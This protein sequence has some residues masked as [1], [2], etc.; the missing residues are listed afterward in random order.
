MIKED[1]VI[2]TFKDS[3]EVNCKFWFYNHD[4]EDKVYVEVGFPDNF[5]DP[6]HSSIPLKKFM[7][8]VNGKKVE[9][10]KVKQ[11]TEYVGEMEFTKNWFVWYADFPAQSVTFIENKYIGNWGGSYYSRFFS[12]EI[13][14]GRT[15]FKNIKEGKIV[16]DH[17]KLA[18][19][20]FVIEG[21]YPIDLVTKQYDDS[22]VITFENYLPDDNEKV[23][24][25]F[26]SYWDFIQPGVYK[27]MLKHEKIS[28]ERARLM[29]NEVFARYGYIFSDQELDKYFKL[30]TWYTPN[31]AFSFDLLTDKEKEFIQLLKEYEESID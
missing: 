15:W 27:N 31:P 22:L 26:F 1:I 4:M 10:T 19:S 21:D 18:T 11:K 5:A 29:R 24:I 25:E 20:N 9:V 14:T 16:F 12:Y 3:C 7:A 17:S 30:K 8:K 2:K 6:L 23:R 13:G 28:K